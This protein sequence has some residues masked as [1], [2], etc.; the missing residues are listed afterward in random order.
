MMNWNKEGP[1]GMEKEAKLATT[2]ILLTESKSEDTSVKIN[3]Y[4][5]HIIK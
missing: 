5:H 2:W 1:T 4:S 3:V